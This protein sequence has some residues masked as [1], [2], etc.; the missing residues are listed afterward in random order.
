MT[1]LPPLSSPISVT[2]LHIIALHAAHD[3]RSHGFLATAER[4]EEEARRIAP[5][6]PAAPGVGICWE[7]VGEDDQPVRLSFTIMCF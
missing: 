1:K 6:L 5:P 7:R 4:W 3:A 2:P